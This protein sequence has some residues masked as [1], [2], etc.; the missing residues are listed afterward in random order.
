MLARFKNYLMLF[1]L[2]SILSHIYVDASE[3]SIKPS[4]DFS[5]KIDTPTIFRSGVG[6]AFSV[7]AAAAFLAS[8][9]IIAQ[10]YK[11]HTSEQNTLKKKSYLPPLEFF[12]SIAT[13]TAF[14]AALFA[15]TET[16]WS[17]KT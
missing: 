8:A 14:I 7:G 9:Y 13:G 5:I 1:L 15:L 2:V 17:K 10:S 12:W 4:D 6:F 11:A 16:A 3:S